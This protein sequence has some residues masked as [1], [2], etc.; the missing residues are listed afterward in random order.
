MIE[1][2]SSI[3]LFSCRSSPLFFLAGPQI[4]VGAVQLGKR[5]LLSSD[6][7]ALKHTHII[8]HAPPNN[9][10]PPSAGKHSPYLH[11][12][13][14]LIIP[15]PIDSIFPPNLFP[16]PPLARRPFSILDNRYRL[17]PLRLLPFSPILTTLSLMGARKQDSHGAQHQNG[18]TAM[19]RPLL[20]GDSLRLAHPSLRPTALHLKG[21][22]YTSTIQP[23]SSLY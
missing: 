12:L 9:P 16:P 14:T 6:S 20:Q 10:N 11:D 5:S 23:L 13:H 15:Q 17:A 2:G 7:L 19:Q 18:H 1:H 21:C 3:H 8:A 4:S 22:H